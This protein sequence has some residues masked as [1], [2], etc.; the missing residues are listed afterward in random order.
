MS[1]EYDPFAEEVDFEEVVEEEEQEQE[2]VQ[3]QAEE[4]AGKHEETVISGTI[5]Q[6]STSTVNEVSYMDSVSVVATSASG[7]TKR[8]LDDTDGG[9][10]TGNTMII[11]DEEGE[12]VPRQERDSKKHKKSVHM[13]AP[14]TEHEKVSYSFALVLIYV[15]TLIMALFY[16]SQW[17][18]KTAW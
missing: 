5:E 2:Q 9:T 15:L 11:N 13:P 10:K 17:L 18:W 7:G 3:E 1:E 16:F 14:S 12:V 8:C 6:H 4:S